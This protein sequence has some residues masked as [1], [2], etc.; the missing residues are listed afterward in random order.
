MP[1]NVS[2]ILKRASDDGLDWGR[3]N[4]PTFTYF[5]DVCEPKQVKFGIVRFV[6]KQ[7]TKA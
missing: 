7:G 4:Y 3:V 5:N 1:R 2:F 6:L